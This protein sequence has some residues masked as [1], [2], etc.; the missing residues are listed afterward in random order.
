M[1][2]TIRIVEDPPP[3]HEATQGVLEIF[4]NT[5]ILFKSLGS[6][7]I[8]VFVLVMLVVFRRSILRFLAHG[9]ANE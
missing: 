5:V 1:A 2:K 6:F 3:D 9:G 8:S 4:M 7:Y